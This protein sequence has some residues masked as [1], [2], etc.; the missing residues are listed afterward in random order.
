MLNTDYWINLL[1][2]RT[3]NPSNSGGGD[4]ACFIVDEVIAG[5]ELIWELNWP[6]S[7]HPHVFVIGIGAFG[8]M[9]G[10][11]GVA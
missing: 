5:Y 3:S 8:G 2:S 1:D 9:V 11:N 6:S 4:S 7:V 10:G